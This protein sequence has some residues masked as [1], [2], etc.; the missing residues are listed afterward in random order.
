MGKETDLLRKMKKKIRKIDKKL[1]ESESIVKEVIKYPLIM[2]EESEPDIPGDE[3]INLH[4]VTAQDLNKKIPDIPVYIDMSKPRGHVRCVWITPSGVQCKN[5]TSGR[6]Y[7]HQHIK[8]RS[9]REYIQIL[10][11]AGCHIPKYNCG[12]RVLNKGMRNYDAYIKKYLERQKAN[13]ERAISTNTE[14]NIAAP[15]KE[16]VNGD[17]VQVP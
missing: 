11:A 1:N 6:P 13:E 15:G 5:K 7:C 16:E 8:N 4:T 3:E 2:P 17:G 10:E 12:A 14:D 9:A